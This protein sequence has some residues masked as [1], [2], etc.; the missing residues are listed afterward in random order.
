MK[1]RLRKMTQ[2]EIDK[3]PYCDSERARVLGGILEII[4][5]PTSDTVKMVQ[6]DR[7]KSSDHAST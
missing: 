1:I 7:E 6:A 2:E 3:L 4:E 5:E